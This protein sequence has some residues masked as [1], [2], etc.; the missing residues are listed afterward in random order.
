MTDLEYICIVITLTIA[1]IFLWV[2]LK[3]MFD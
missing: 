2:V 1:L 3:D